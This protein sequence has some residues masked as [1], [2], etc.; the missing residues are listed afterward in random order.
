MTDLEGR[1]FHLAGW[2]AATQMTVTTQSGL[3]CRSR[4]VNGHRVPDAWARGGAPEGIRRS[5]L[6]RSSC[7]LQ[8]R[9]IEIQGGSEPFLVLCGDFGQQLHLGNSRAIE[10]LDVRPVDLDQIPA[11]SRKYI[12]TQP[13]GSSLTG[14]RKAL[15]SSA[16]I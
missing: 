15:E 14:L 4:A 11:G 13:S 8:M 10:R 16:P 7:G 3:H 12:W 9:P 2:I 1:N 6:S 5:S